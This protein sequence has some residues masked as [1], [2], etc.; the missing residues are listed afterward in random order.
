MVNLEWYRSFVQVY[1]VGTVSKAAESLHLTQPAVS[2]HVAGLEATLG[3]PL[4]QRMPR[5]M[6]PT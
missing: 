2:Q 3:T 4:F 6:V 1:R 5:R